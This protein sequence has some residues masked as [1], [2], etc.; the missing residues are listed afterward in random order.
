[1]K[2]ESGNGST[3]SHSSGDDD[4]LEFHF[5]YFPLRDY[6]KAN[7]KYSFILHLTGF[8]NDWFILRLEEKMAKMEPNRISFDLENE[9]VS[10]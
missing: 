6:D 10:I 3:T 4:E 8:V 5:D 7:E 1:M 2:T 9:T